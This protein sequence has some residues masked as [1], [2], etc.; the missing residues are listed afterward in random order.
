MRQEKDYVKEAIELKIK[1]T[2]SK[3]KYEQKIASLEREIERL[4]HEIKHP[5]KPLMV[6]AKLEDLLIIV[7]NECEIPASTIL[8]KSRTREY[9]IARQMFCFIATRH[10]GY[11]LERVGLFLN[12]HHSTI[13]HGAN[14]INDAID[15][16]FNP[17]LRIY[18]NCMSELRAMSSQEN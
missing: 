18:E 9:A 3:Q 14:R 4:R 8:C 13:I 16:K 11:K 7:S 1:L 15:L 12:R 10:L 5:F 2:R 17:E 6:D